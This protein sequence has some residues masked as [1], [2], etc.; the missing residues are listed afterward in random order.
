MLRAGT[1]RRPVYAGRSAA[2]ALGTALAI[3]PAPLSVR[4]AWAQPQ[5]APAPGAAA[6]SAPPVPVDV[7][8]ATEIDYDAAA[9]EYTFRGDQVLVTRGDQRLVAPIII[10]RAATRRAELP[11]RG[12]V[13]APTEALTAD[14]I[15]AEMGARHLVAEGRVEGRFLDDGVWASITADRVEVR[16]Q[17][18]QR[19]IVADGHVVAVRG[20]EQ[21]RGDH[22]A[23]DRATRHATVEGHA[24]ATRGGDR[25][26]ADRIDVDL[27]TR[28][29]VAA[30]HV[31]V[32]RAADAMHGTADRA[33]YTGGTDTTVLSG[34]ASLTRNRDV[35]T[36]DTITVNMTGHHATADG[37]S[38][39]VAYPQ[40]GSGQPGTPP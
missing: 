9:E 28:D 29:A 33:T 4:S 34:H 2:V 38:T 25:L 27:G 30:G 23:Y 36:A 7:T 19:D 17:G 10:Y 1:R 31:V 8:G 6:V 18:N 5:S 15:V 24:V 40:Q 16:D 12:T 14:H 26:Q 35:V 11:E 13:S 20:D 32:D 21:L 22:V 3:L 37:Q 39:V